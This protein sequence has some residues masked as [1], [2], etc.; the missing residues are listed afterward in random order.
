MPWT[1]NYF[2]VGNSLALTALAG[3]IPIFYFFWALAIKKMKGHIAGLTTL[4]L[5]IIDV[6]IV[7][8]MPFGLAISATLLGIVNGLFPILWIVITALFLYNLV[9]EAGQFDIIKNSIASISPDRRLQTLLIA[10]SFGAFL[11]GAAGFG[12]P[13]AITSALL[14]GLGFEPLYAAGLSLVANTAP[15][16]FGGIGIPVVTMAGVTGLDSNLI[17]RAVVHQLPLIAIIVPFYLVILLAGWKGIKDVLPAILVNAFSFAILQ[18]G[19]AMY[20]GANLPDIVA[21]LGS[22]LITALFLKAWKP[23]NIWRFPH[24]RDT[25]IIEHTKYSG[26]QIFKA[27]SPFVIL[28]AM[29][30]IWGTNGFKTWADKSHLYLLIKSWPGLD[31]LVYKTAPIVAK[32]AIY[33]A[34]YRMDFVAAA[35]TAILLT[36]ILSMIVLQISPSRGLKVF[37]A[38]FKQLIYPIITVSCVLGFAFI[39]NYSGLS[40][41]LALLL[42]KTGQAFPFFSPILGW[43]GVFLTG[44]DT[45]SNALF[46][47]L[48][49]VTATQLHINPLVTVAGNCSGGGVGKMISPQSIAVGAATTNMVGR[50]GEIF[51]FSLKHSVLFV[52]LLGVLVYLQ[53]YVFPW[54]MPTI[55]T[56]M[57]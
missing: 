12:I 52:C 16:A 49:Q 24:E 42:A 20:L 50:E 54:M 39:A 2:A 27:W 14:I 17:S 19:T 57:H 8:K 47:K 3:A 21:S 18:W 48:Q 29:V 36:C 11:E 13:V 32:P 44:S 43:F 4:A 34:N 25:A 56:V 53:A 15:V 40:F 22:L 46:G 10:F 26:A 31:K 30:G 33:A 37:G 23:K 6:I 55:S 38:T 5:S 7:F 51:K 1:Q 9:V 45:S 28:T 41:T 35:G